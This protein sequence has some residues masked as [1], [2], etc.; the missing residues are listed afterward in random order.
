MEV[1][2]GILYEI[3]LVYL[4]DLLAH[5][6]D[7]MRLLQAIDALLARLLA[8]GLKLHP[9]KCSLFA[10]EIR[11]CGHVVSGDGIKVCPS[12]V[13][14]LLAVPV[15]ENAAQL[16]QFLAAMNWMRSK[17]P[18]YARICGP[19][20]EFLNEVLEG[21]RRTAS[22]AAGIRLAEQGWNDEL[23]R[24]F[25]ELKRLLS[26]AVTLGHPNPEADFCLFT[27]ASDNYWG[28]VLT[29]LL[30][31]A[32]RPGGIHSQDHVPTRVLEW[33]VQGRFATVVGG[34]QG[35][36]R[37]PGGVPAVGLSALPAEGIQNLHGSQELT[38]HLRQFGERVENFTGG[39]GS[40][41]AVGSS[42]AVVR[43]YHRTL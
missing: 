31:G 8:A 35:G 12:R 5:A 28:A 15:P 13:S 23:T 20:Q 37:D 1:M 22:V 34:G 21:R 36:V 39:G 14:A 18:D 2:A 26:K 10:E 7:P 38:V 17:L 41:G 40:A 43:L 11:W 9:R 24:A 42:V 16:Q 4:D 25:D 3:V 32:S 27:D 29:Q 6:G 30:P 33:F 19:L